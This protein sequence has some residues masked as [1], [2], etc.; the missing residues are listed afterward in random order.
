M[1]LYHIIAN[2]TVSQC[3]TNETSSKDA[4]VEELVEVKAHAQAARGGWEAIRS[5]LS[6]LSWFIIRQ[7]G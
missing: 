7:V 6:L 4:K 5:Y 3:I 2:D 1:C